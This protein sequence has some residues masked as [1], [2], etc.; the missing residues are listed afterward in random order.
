[1]VQAAPQA[2]RLAEIALV[3]EQRDRQARE[4]RSVPSVEPSSTTITLVR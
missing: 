2:L 1:V 4:L 3:G